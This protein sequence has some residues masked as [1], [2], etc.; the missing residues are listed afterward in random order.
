[1]QLRSN[2]PVRSSPHKVARRDIESNAFVVEGRHLRMVEPNKRIFKQNFTIPSGVKIEPGP[3]N[4]ALKDKLMTNSIF[5]NGK[6]SEY[7]Q[8]SWTTTSLEVD[9]DSTIRSSG[10]FVVGAHTHH[11]HGGTD[12]PAVK[13]LDESLMATQEENE[14]SYEL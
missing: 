10:E 8:L 7:K 6:L 14:Q 3:H 12:R 9:S 5:D 11:D 2:R 1:M 13:Y 4:V